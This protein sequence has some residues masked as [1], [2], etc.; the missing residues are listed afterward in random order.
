[1]HFQHQR[2]ERPEKTRKV[3][4][5]RIISMVKKNNFTASNQVKSTLGETGVAL[6]MSKNQGMPL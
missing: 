4:D 5:D 1:M 6:S 3:H 2:P